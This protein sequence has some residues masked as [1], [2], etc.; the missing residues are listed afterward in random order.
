[1]SDFELMGFHILEIMS[2]E[3]VEAR[4]MKNIKDMLE[5]Y[6]DQITVEQRERIS[7]KPMG[8]AQDKWKN[9]KEKFKDGGQIRA[10]SSSGNLGYILIR[11]DYV[12][13]IFLTTIN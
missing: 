2:I 9:F 5:K 12:V 4:E 11:D 13:D 6:G 8:F 7:S 3:Q 1:M 10:T